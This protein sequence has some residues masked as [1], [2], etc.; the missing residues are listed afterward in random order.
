MPY[1]VVRLDL[2][3]RAF[4]VRDADRPRRADR[5]PQTSSSSCIWP[6]P[7][8][9]TSGWPARAATARPRC[10]SPT[11]RN[12]AGAGWHT[13]HVD[14]YGVTS[15]TEVCVRIATAYGR[16]RNNKVRSHLE[17]L[18]SRL[19][20]QLT[21]SGIGVTLSPARTPAVPRRHAHDRGRAARP[22]AAGCTSRTASRRW[23]SSTS[24]RTCSAPARPSTDCCARTCSTTATPRP[25]STPARS[26]R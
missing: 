5:P 21:T 12:L 2:M 25:T 17:S 7:T 23:S 11:R 18:G 20:V 26:R 24:S 22:A 13:V 15:L 19:G 16:L 10:C 8:A 6:R 4:P 9:P 14:F 1:K 3:P